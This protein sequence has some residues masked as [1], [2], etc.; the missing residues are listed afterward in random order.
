[1]RQC[2]AAK[3][4]MRGVTA[5]RPD[6]R[7]AC[8]ARSVASARRHSPA[9][10][11]AP[12]AGRRAAGAA[13][14]SAGGGDRRSADRAAIDRAIAAVFP[15]LVRDLRGLPAIGQ[16]G[17]EVKGESSGSGTIISADGYVVTNHHVAGRP[18]R[19]VCTLSTREEVP[20]ELVGTDPLVG[21]R[22]VQAASRRRRRRFRSAR[23]G[24]SAKLARGQTVLA[25]GSPLALSQSVTRGIVSNPSMI[26]P[27]SL[28][29]GA[30]PARRRGR[31]DRSCGG[32][33]TTRRSIRETRAARSSI[34]PARSSASTRSAIGLGGAI[35]A[36]LAQV[37]GRGVIKRDGRVAASWTGVEC[38]RGRPASPRPGALVSL[39]RE[40]SPAEAAGLQDRRLLVRVN[41][42]PV[43]VQ[44]AEQLP[45]VNQTLFGLPIGKPATLVVR[46]GAARTSRL[47]VTPVERPAAS[48]MPVGAAQRGGW[49]GPTSSPSEAREMAPGHD[50]RRAHR[51]PAP[52]RAVG[53]GEAAARPQRHHRRDRRTAGAVARR[54]GRRASTRGA[55]HEAE[56][57]SVL[58]GFDRGRE[59][60]ADRHRNRASRSRRSAAER[61]EQ[62][63]DAGQR[64]GPDADRWPSGSASRARPACA[65]RACSTAPRRSRSATSFSPST[66]SRCARARRTTRTCSRPTIRRYR[67][68]STVDADRVARRQ[69]SRRCRSMLGPARRLAAR[70]GGLR[71]RRSSSS[72]ARNMAEI[73]PATIRAGAPPRAS[74]SSR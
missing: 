64:A 72:G 67:I 40:R 19:I 15:S 16:G 59:R 36:N 9:A 29:G 6:L 71:R 49:S 53:A 68:G 58:V 34:L 17:R 42:T 10:L 8:I 54:S 26:M 41:G 50:R 12:G 11:H 65:S 3:G 21:H 61:G 23:F 31:R 7:P 46:R 30:R 52:G 38:S 5:H 55:R 47:T 57:P 28:G 24:D 51:Q 4:T 44:F 60:R 74:S 35:P 2:R 69:R 20:A 45:P 63:V 70:N 22:G 39:G 18:Q 1:M 27:Q 33:V 25:M 37:R 66:A 62:G 73:G 56:A 32:S 14:Q 48:S 43:D 13:A